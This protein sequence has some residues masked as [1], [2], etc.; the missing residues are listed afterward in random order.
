MKRLPGII[1]VSNKKKTER[2]AKAR[3]FVLL[4]QDLIN[5]IKQDQMPKGNVLEIARVAAIMAV[6]KTEELI[7]HCHNIPIESADIEFQLSTDGVIIESVVK[8]C[9]KTG[10]EMEAMVACS[11]AALTI[12]DVCKMFAKDIEIKDVYLLE[13]RGGKSGSYKRK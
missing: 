10:V 11:V 12:Y 5:K 2:I 8:T 9:A 13:K 6:K 1:D 3:A 4:N 7:P